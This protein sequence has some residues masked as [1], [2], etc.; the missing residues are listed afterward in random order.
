MSE[1]HFD[2]FINYHREIFIDGVKYYPK[3]FKPEVLLEFDRF[4]YETKKTLKKAGLL[5]NWYYPKGRYSHP[6]QLA[7]LKNSDLI[8]LE[9][10]GE[11]VPAAPTEEEELK[12]VKQQ[13]AGLFQQY[14]AILQLKKFFER[15]KNIEDL[16]N[17]RTRDGKT[18]EAELTALEGELKTLLPKMNKIGD[19]IETASTQGGG[20]LNLL[21]S[22][23]QS[24][25][26]S[27]FGAGQ[28]QKL[29][30]FQ[31]E[32]LSEARMMRELF[33]EQV[34][35]N[36]IRPERQTEIQ[37][38]IRQLVQATRDGGSRLPDS[39]INQLAREFKVD[40]QII[41]GV[42]HHMVDPISGLYGGIHVPRT[43]RA[44]F[45][46]D[47][48]PLPAPVPKPDPAAP[49]T[50]RSVEPAA[51]PDSPPPTATRSRDAGPMPPQ[52]APES[53][54]SLVF[55]VLGTLAAAAGI[56]GLLAAKEMRNRRQRIENLIDAADEVKKNN[57]QAKGEIPAPPPAVEAIE[58]LPQN[59]LQAL[60]P[61]FPWIR[62]FKGVKCEDLCAVIKGLSSKEQEQIYKLIGS[63]ALKK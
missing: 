53:G 5:E 42:A 25:V 32:A 22:G 43:D 63:P 34:A 30:G 28:S 11:N 27:T 36:A 59:Y 62:Y 52:P 51:G 4:A 15:N 56:G 47:D 38:A 29:S 23:A 9:K 3:Y 14:N 33:A 17:F 48:S 7:N 26:G 58:E 31:A 8:L 39:A 61:E 2:H 41:R 45:T 1:K 6:L 60:P 55:K 12:I 35:D 37:N 24:F 19:Q 18:F 44:G 46:I 16:V 13:K 54:G 40:K 57:P 10:A 50:G 49:P 20:L 21:K